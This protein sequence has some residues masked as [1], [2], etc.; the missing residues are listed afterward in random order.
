MSK[1]SISGGVELSMANIPSLENLGESFLYPVSTYSRMEA[2][3]LKICSKG[4]QCIKPV[5]FPSKFE[6]T[7]SFLGANYL[8]IHPI[9]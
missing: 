2:G 7:Q 1:N 5:L 9:E 6:A 3:A 8:A 4:K